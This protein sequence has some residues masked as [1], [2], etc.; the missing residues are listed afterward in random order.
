[1]TRQAQTR[2]RARSSVQIVFFGLLLTTGLSFILAS[3]LVLSPQ[4]T[5]QK[6]QA[7]GQ[8]I[9][10]PFRV[11]FVSDLRTKA[12]KQRAAAAVVDVYDQLDRQ[13]GREQVGLALQ[14]LAFID[15][16][17]ADP[18]TSQE[19]RHFA[20]QSIRAVPLS[21]QV[22]SDTLALDETQWKTVQLETRRVLDE[23]M[24]REIKSGQEDASR[25]QV[26]T[27]IGFDLSETQ[28]AIVDE[29]ASALVKANRIYNAEKTDQAR[30]AAMD[31][32]KPQMRTLEQNQVVVRSGE[33]VDDEDLEALA[34]LGLSSPGPN[35]FAAGSAVLVALLFAVATS[36]Y[37]A[38][39]EP[40]IYGAPRYLLLLLLLLLLFAFVA[41]WGVGLAEFQPYLI[42]LGTA[43]MLAS[44]LL[45]VRV[46][47]VVHLII[48]LIVGYLTQGQLDLF[49]Y[50]L[51][52]GLVGL[53]AIRRVQRINTFVWAGSYVMTANVITLATFAL[54]GDNFD[55][56]WL[57]QLGFAGLIN[58]ALTAI[59]TLGGY[60]LLGQV[61]QI[62]TSLQLV[63]LARPTHPLMRD[64]LIKAPGT[65]HHSI[66]VG[67]M[68]EQAAEAVGADA[69]LARVGA[70]Y[71][72]IGKTMRPYFFTEN[73]MDGDNPHDLLDPETS[74]Q[75]IRSHTSEG[76]ALAKKYRLPRVLQAFIEEHHGTATISYFYHKAKQEAGADQVRE[77]DYRH[78][79]TRPQSKETA[80]VMMADTCEAA[81]RS[82]RP[83]DADELEA[84]I[85][86]LI[87]AQ[88]SSG[89]LYHAPLTLQEIETVT[90][91]FIDTLQG[92][93]HPRVQYPPTEKELPAP[94][95]GLLQ[96]PPDSGAA[97]E[98]PDPSEPDTIWSKE[99]QHDPG[100]D[101]PAV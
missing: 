35:W 56:L 33:I 65:Y 68:A 2:W 29:I 32:V 96:A 81:V 36:V 100:A 86:K 64:L 55:T 74:A 9:I 76:L 58:G 27:L 23:I 69:L 8:D 78:V 85:R 54:L 43:A 37:L 26:R 71:H 99:G 7:A 20:L 67:N 46:G 6:G 41:K 42:P 91:S 52:G 11:E 30:Q 89:Q 90:R 98:T 45:N 73:Q 22:I 31:A 101:S 62:T 15:S 28:T 60:Y 47:L 72:D 51:A 80:I 24:K 79:G 92:V 40:Q 48:C 12:E 77:Q 61:F 93:F 88:I 34:A 57:T 83:H 3:D 59:L 53:F 49:W 38:N 14:V 39:A 17:R 25:R 1:M 16:V 94:A 66:M 44:A 95:A 75:I 5:I 82:V 4:I 50:Q 21:A 19:Y 13:V 18:Y 87:A 97:A 10:A 70:F 63:D 84:L